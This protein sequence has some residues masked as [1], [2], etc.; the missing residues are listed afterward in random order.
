MYVFI[1]IDQV[2]HHLASHY[3]FRYRHISSKNTDIFVYVC[4]HACVN[5]KYVVPS[6]N[7]VRGMLCRK[8]DAPEVKMKSVPLDQM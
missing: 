2:T 5:I 3:L 8:Y 7:I 4:A 6:Y 1:F